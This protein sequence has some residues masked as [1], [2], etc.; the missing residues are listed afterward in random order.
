MAPRQLVRERSSGRNPRPYGGPVEPGSPLA[1]LPPTALDAER[2]WDA[3]GLGCDPA[4]EGAVGDELAG[5]G[6]AG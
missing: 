4:G 3:V 6:T 2:Y 1:A 5:V